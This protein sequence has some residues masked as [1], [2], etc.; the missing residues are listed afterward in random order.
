MKR[1]RLAI[2][3]VM[4]LTLSGL[5]IA[6]DK[7][8]KESDEISTE[9]EDVKEEL[10]KKSKKLA[11][12]EKDKTDVHKYLDSLKEEIRN[13]K[14][15]NQELIAGQKRLEAEIIDLKIETGAIPGNGNGDVTKKKS[16][17]AKK[18]AKGDKESAQN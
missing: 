13:L 12:S 4:T 10:G 17:R 9:L 15:E 3:L 8:K 2:I 11:K 5:I 14:I 16:K 7:S 18:E 1:F 6:C